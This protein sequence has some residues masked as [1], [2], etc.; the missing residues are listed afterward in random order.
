MQKCNRTSQKGLR[1]N[2]QGGFVG[3]GFCFILV[4]AYCCLLFFYKYIKIRKLARVSR[5]LKHKDVKGVLSENK[6]IAE[7]L[8]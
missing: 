4:S 3:W 1:N 8:N 2:L 7:K 5:G 6:A